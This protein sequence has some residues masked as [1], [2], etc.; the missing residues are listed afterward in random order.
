MKSTFVYQSRTQFT[1]D[2][3]ELGGYG[4]RPSGLPRSGVMDEGSNPEAPVRILVVDDNRDAAISLAML[5]SITG[6]EA[7]T[8][9]DGEDALRVAEMMQPDLIFLDLGMPK[10]TGYEVCRRLRQESQEKRVVIVALTGW[11]LAEDRRKSF[12]AGFD[13]H[14][15]KPVDPDS[16]LRT[17]RE[18][19]A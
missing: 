9:F 2:L 17:L 19:L 4:E 6:H 16:L 1:R 14:L 11:G 7:R 8:A 18:L 15:V 12:A 5:L 13:A 3:P 10:L